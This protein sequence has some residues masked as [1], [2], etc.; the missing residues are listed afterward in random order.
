[1]DVIGLLKEL[2]STGLFDAVLLVAIP[3]LVGN[4]ISDAKQELRQ[5]F[6]DSIDAKLNDFREVVNSRFDRIDDK[7]VRIDE[8]FGRIDDRLLQL[9]RKNDSRAYDMTL[10]LIDVR[11]RLANIEGRMGIYPPRR[12]V[13]PPV[14]EPTTEPEGS[15][16]AQ[17]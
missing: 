9:D 14:P 1:M 8:K 10:H 6:N 7:F 11:E 13:E 3:L 17:S 12:G 15:E 16:T 5:E 2:S 4:W